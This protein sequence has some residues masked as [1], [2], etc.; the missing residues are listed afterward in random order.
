MML[1]GAAILPD[2]DGVGFSLDWTRPTKDRLRHRWT[3]RGREIE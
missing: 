3:W 1:A 2:A